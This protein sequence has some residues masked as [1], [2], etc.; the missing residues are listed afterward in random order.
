MNDS[1]TTAAATTA[2]E[3]ATNQLLSNITAGLV[4]V[5]LVPNLL[6]L[7]VS[8]LTLY[9][10]TTTSVLHANLK[11]VICYEILAVKLYTLCRLADWLS[12]QVGVVWPGWFGVSIRLVE[13]C[14]V[15]DLGWMGHAMLAER[16]YAT[17]MV[18]TYEQSRWSPWLTASWFL[19]IFFGV[20]A[21]EAPDAIFPDGKVSSPTMFL[22]Y[23]NAILNAVAYI[24][25]G[26]LHAYNRRRYAE[27]ERLE[28]RMAGRNREHG[29]LSERYQLAENV[30]TLRQ[31]SP[32]LFLHL[33]TGATSGVTVFI[34]YYKVRLSLSEGWNAIVG[35][36]KA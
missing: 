11:L 19:P 29:T 20:N 5:E 27:N 21:L 24:A 6:I 3:S 12:S 36:I 13:R 35:P 33:W 34:W 10:I 14:S 8:L 28:R 30:R 1:T 31:L 16:I 2:S 23:A 25:L 32:V 4:Y 17:R 22:L 9:V 18:D 7:P 15:S 26:V